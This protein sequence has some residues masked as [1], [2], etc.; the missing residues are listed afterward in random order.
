MREILLGARRIAVVGLSDNPDRP[1]HSVASFL[2]AR[3]YTV[4]AVNPNV[5]EVLGEP[6]LGSLLD[7]EGPIDIV[8][9]FRRAEHS[10]AVARQAV[11]VGVD[12]LWLQLGVVSD[13]AISIAEAGGLCAVQDRCIRTEHQRL[14]GSGARHLICY[15]ISHRSLGKFQIGNSLRSAWEYADA[16]TSHC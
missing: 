8:N 9:V 2:K 4:V 14:L 12:T 13:A 6:S 1:S 7:I 16:T 15:A 5:T 3:S 10:P 11:S